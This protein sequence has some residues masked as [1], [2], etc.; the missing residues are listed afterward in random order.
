VAA[1]REARI[2]DYQRKRI[3]VTLETAGRSKQEAAVTEFEHLLQDYPSDTDFLHELALE[4][5]SQSYEAKQAFVT[6]IVRRYRAG[7]YKQLGEAINALKGEGSSMGQL[8]AELANTLGDESDLVADAYGELLVRPATTSLPAFN[9]EYIA[10]SA[11]KQLG[12]RESLARIPDILDGHFGTVSAQGI[13]EFWTRQNPVEASSYVRDL[14]PSKARDSLITHMIFEIA[15]SEDMEMAQ[16]WAEY[17][18][19]D[20]RK[21]ALNHIKTRISVLEAQRRLREKN[22]ET[23]NVPTKGE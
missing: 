9:Y 7:D 1:S 5:F 12:P 6:A 8:V 10:Y 17:L 13:L 22:N 21:T 3:R 20:A 16:S 14:P 15:K 23:P 4:M 2:S 11:A 18:Q 19:G